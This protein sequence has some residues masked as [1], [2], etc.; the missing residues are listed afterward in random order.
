MEVKIKKLNPNAVIPKYAKNGDAGMDLVA[1]SV[2]S[3]TPE[4]ITYGMGIAL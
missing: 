1:T 4:Q 3:D 2:I